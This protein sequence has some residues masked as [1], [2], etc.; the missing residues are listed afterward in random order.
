[1][2]SKNDDTKIT[3]IG[4]NHVSEHSANTVEEEIRAIRPDL[5]CVE[6]CNSRV[7]MLD[8]V[9]KAES[10]RSIIDIL[11]YLRP[12]NNT[13]RAIVLFLGIPQLVLRKLNRL[14]QGDM[15]RGIATAQD[16]GSD[17]DAIDEDI[18]ESS[19]DLSEVIAP[20]GIIRALRSF[21][22]GDAEALDTLDK[23]DEAVEQSEFSSEEL[24]PSNLSEGPNDALF[25]AHRIMRDTGSDVYRVLVSERN[26]AMVARLAEHARSDD[27]GSI[28]CVVG[29]LHV[30][31]MVERFEDAFEPG[32]VVKIV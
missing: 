13:T 7:E 3:L 21:L 9:G 28:V 17:W 30:P 32:T 26:E 31:G 16:I 4:T 19:S 6:L 22:S 29:R 24:H 5:V 14:E 25:E 23:Y 8:L 1:M 20:N 15:E 18:Y 11:Q 2:T 10:G 12:M 27:V